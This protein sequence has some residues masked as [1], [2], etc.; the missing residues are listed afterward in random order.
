MD[1]LFDKSQKKINTVPLVFK[2]YLYNRI[3]FNHRLISIRGARG[4]G[5]TTLLLQMGATL[6][7]TR[8]LYVALDDLFF[9]ENSLYSLADQF[10][11]TGG[12][13]LLLD[14]VHKYPNWSREIKL[15]YDDFTDLQ[16]V[17]TSS[18]VLNIYRG[19]SDLSRRASS[20]ILHEMSF[21][22]YLDFYYKLTFPPLSLDDIVKEHEAISLELL[23]RFKPFK[24]FPGYL[25]HGSYPYFE[26]DEDDYYQKMLNT[27][28]LVLDID[29]PAIQNIDYE[30]I[31]KFKRLLYVLATNVPYTPNISGLSEKIKLNRNA[32]VQAIQLLGKAELIHTVY[33]QNRSIS[34]LNK[35][36]KIWLHNTNLNYALGNKNPETGNVRETFFISQLSLDHRVSLPA[37][38]D[39]LIDERYV[40]EVG[41]ENK[42]QKQIQGTSNAFL[43]KD[44]IEA[45]AL[46][47]IPLWLFGF[48][49]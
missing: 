19:E 32:M 25:K 24:Y 34:S 45:G 38:G 16:V 39:F 40:F 44:H 8:A 49:Y 15:I 9:T 20:Y 2:R 47:S 21:R 26:G 35:P 29:L 12:E 23:G 46:K 27:V 17:F 14:E 31:A 37:K 4:T 48:L 3:N 30:N 13:L 43:V 36:D 7:K 10:S 5:K 28:N 22:E 11:K 33:K 6:K 1:L 18:S 42:T 41:G